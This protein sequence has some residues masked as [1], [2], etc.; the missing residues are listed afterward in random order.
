MI[1]KNGGV[2]EHSFTGL[3]SSKVHS[4]Y[5]AFRRVGLA[6]VSSTASVATARKWNVTFYDDDYAA[7]GEVL[8]TES[9][10]WGASATP[11]AD[12]TKTGHT[13]NR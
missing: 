8:K 4:V 1:A 11:P 12:P 3:E 7:G 5:A 13:F 9:V 6:S 10:H 2:I